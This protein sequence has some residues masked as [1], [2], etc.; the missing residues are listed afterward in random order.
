[1]GSKFLGLGSFVEGDRRIFDVAICKESVKSVL[2][3]FNV[4]LFK[5]LFS[6]VFD[7]TSI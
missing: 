5:Y 1:M 7:A 3:W 4:F 2:R 6:L